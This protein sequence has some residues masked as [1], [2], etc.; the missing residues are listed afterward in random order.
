MAPATAA[1]MTSTTQGQKS[2]AARQSRQRLPPLPMNDAKIIIRP[3]GGLKVKEQ[4][5]YQAARAIMEACG[6]KF[7]EDKF[8]VR[9]RPGSNIIIASAS[10]EEAAGMI[11]KINGLNFDG[12]N[13]DVN[14]YV[15]LPEDIKRAAFHG[16]PPGIAADLLEFKLRLRTQGVEILSARMLGKS[17]TALVTF[18]GPFIPKYVIFGACECKTHPYRPTRQVCFVCGEQGRRSD[19]CPTPGTRICRQCGATSSPEGHQC[20]PKCLYAEGPT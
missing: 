17:E 8:L 1:G 19:V 7:G 5:T 3:K 11:R 20:Q 2:G 10:D 6:R 16:L 14:A 4:N 18:D 9:L 13:Y 15:A 12:Q